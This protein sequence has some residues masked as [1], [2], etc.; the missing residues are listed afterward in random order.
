MLEPHPERLARYTAGLEMAGMKLTGQRA[1]V[2]TA[3][4]AAPGHPTV[5]E[6]HESAKELAASISLATVY[7]TMSALKELG[8]V[9]ELGAADGASISYELD[10]RPHANLVCV[11][12]RQVYDVHLPAV[13][14]LRTAVETCSGFQVSDTRILMS[15]VCAKCGGH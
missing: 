6:I 5:H 2:C 10:P 12:C 11:R 8:L 13:A 1:A 7:N 15:G 4:A 3:L 9:F 14:D